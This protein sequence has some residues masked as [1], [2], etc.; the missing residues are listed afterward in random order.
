MHVHM[1]Y[2]TDEIIF[3]A[4]FKIFIQTLI[5]CLSKNDGA[6]LHLEITLSNLAQYQHFSR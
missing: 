1:M 3:I 6:L 5:T 2:T 4:F